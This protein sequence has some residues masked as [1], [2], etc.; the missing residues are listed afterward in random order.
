MNRSTVALVVVGMLAGLLLALTVASAAPGAPGVPAGR[1]L[2]AGG[3]LGT[4]VEV[5]PE[6]AKAWQELGKLRARQHDV[7]WE[8]WTLQSKDLVDKKAVEQKTDELQRIQEAT[9]DAQEELGDFREGPPPGPGMGQ[10]QGRGGR[11]GGAMRGQM[12]AGR[13]A[14]RSQMGP[15]MGRARGGQGLGPGPGA[16]RGQGPGPQSRIEVTPEST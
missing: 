13:G 7:L 8:L 6:S 16:G 5:T 4:G 11:R 3:V 1:G 10:G 15:G 2:R 14:M 9:R 12:H